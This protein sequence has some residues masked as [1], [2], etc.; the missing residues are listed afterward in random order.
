VFV[1]NDISKPWNTIKFEFINHEEKVEQ[2]VSIE[3]KIHFAEEIKHE[4]NKDISS[5]KTA[6]EQESA[7]KED[8]SGFITCSGC[9][10]LNSLDNHFCVFCDRNLV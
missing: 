2:K 10:Q 9:D 3:K 7:I 8:I 1:K 6:A 4:E 5:A